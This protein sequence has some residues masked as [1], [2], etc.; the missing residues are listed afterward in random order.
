VARGE[1]EPA[2]RDQVN[3]WPLRRGRCLVHR[4]DNL[5]ILMRAG[6]REDVGETRADDLRLVAH[7]AGDDDAAILR[8]RLADRLQA[9]LL[10]AVE[11]AAGVDEHDVG[12]RIIGRQ[13]IAVGTQFGQNPFAVDECLRTAERNHADFRLG[14]EGLD[15]HDRPRA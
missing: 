12:A 13:A 8:H 6:D 7:A 14:G 2:F 9:F 4:F 15:C 5:F 11:E 10:R 3:E 1:L